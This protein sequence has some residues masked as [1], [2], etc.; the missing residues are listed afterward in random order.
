MRTVI[1]ATVVLAAPALVVVAATIPWSAT[2]SSAPAAAPAQ[3][4]A[5]H[6]DALHPDAL[7]P[8]APVPLDAKVPDAKAP[9]Y[10]PVFDAGKPKLDAATDA[11]KD[12]LPPLFDASKPIPPDP[13]PL[14]SDAVFVLTVKFDK[15]TVSIVNVK[16]EK[17][18]TK[19]AVDRRFG[20]FAAELLSG[21]TLVERVR[22]DF[23][24]IN[25]DS[26]ASEVYEKGLVVQ[27]DVKIPDSDR[28]NKLEIWDRANDKRW[29][30]PYPP[31][32]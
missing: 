20:R 18:A 1:R 13:T 4:D 23:P 24:L 32:P 31:K 7:R 19:A 14:V 10:P 26:V 15:G 6:P 17:L 30:F 28:P 5:P 9:P 8:D 2:A 25:D 11:K 3:A 29:S 12:A 27:I 22:F 21:P 16:R